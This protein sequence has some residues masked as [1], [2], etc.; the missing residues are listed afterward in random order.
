MKYQENTKFQ[1]LESTW[2]VSKS[3]AISSFNYFLN[4]L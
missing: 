4:E 2:T 3:E 1:H